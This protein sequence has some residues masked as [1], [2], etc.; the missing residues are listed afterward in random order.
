M[1]VWEDGECWIE[2]TYVFSMHTPEGIKYP[3]GMLKKFLQLTKDKEEAIVHIPTDEIFDLF[4]KHYRLTPISI[5]DKTY[6][7]ER[8]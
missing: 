8:Y 3:R 6:K 5:E 4:I 2:E 7:A 1:R